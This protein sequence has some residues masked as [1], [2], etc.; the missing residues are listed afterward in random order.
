M[1]CD[2]TFSS[3]P[4]KRV[5]YNPTAVLA[6][7]T[8]YNLGHTLKEAVNECGRRFKVRP[9]EPTIADGSNASL[10]PAPS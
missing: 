2:R 6:A 4:I 3:E 9:S 8:Y 1:S 5:V 7:V 10:R